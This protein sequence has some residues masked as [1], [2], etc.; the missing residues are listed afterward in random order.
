M[1][2]RS[3]LQI[4]PGFLGSLQGYVLA[5]LDAEAATVI[6]LWPDGRIALLNSA[7]TTFAELNSGEATLRRWGLGASLLSA[8]SGPLHDYYERAFASVRRDGD[9]FE[10]TYSCHS[11]SCEREY[12]LHVHALTGGSLL[13]MH[14]L[15]V[16][17]PL[18]RT[19][20]EALTWTR[21]VDVQG[22][23]HQCSNCRRVRR[24]SDVTAWDWVAELVEHPASNT[25]HGICSVCCGRYYAELGNS[26]GAPAHWRPA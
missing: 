4:A 22:L 5:S 9:T 26:A 25:S 6:G 1:A 15:I 3:S 12:R 20:A 8:V 23:V 24:A 18:A 21:Y 17:L 2:D 19:A 16:T 14:T 10:Q 11:G 7:W 13:L